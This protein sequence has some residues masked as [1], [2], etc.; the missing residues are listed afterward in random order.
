MIK[1]IILSLFL[2]FIILFA[3]IASILSTTG[4][5]TDRFNRLIINTIEQK[6]I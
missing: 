3:L 1:K 6:K 5:Q 4:I 2:I